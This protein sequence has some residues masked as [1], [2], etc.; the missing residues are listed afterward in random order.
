M[1]LLLQPNDPR[2]NRNDQK[3]SEQVELVFADDVTP[4]AHESDVNAF[5]V[6]LRDDINHTVAIRAIDLQIEN[7]TNQGKLTGITTIH[8]LL[9]GTDDPPYIP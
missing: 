9:I 8:Y 7:I 6:S 3:L 2:P 1:T 4:S 5:L